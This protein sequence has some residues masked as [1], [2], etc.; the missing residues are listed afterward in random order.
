MRVDPIFSITRI[1]DEEPRLREI[2]DWE[3]ERILDISLVIRYHDTIAGYVD[4][5][6]TVMMVPGLS[7]MYRMPE[8]WL[9]QKQME[10]IVDMLCTELCPTPYPRADTEDEFWKDNPA[11]F[12]CGFR[13]SNHHNNNLD[14]EAWQDTPEHL[15]F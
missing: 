14:C 9:Y 1:T 3:P 5:Y 12:K 15:R 4:E 10:Y 7:S 8:F 6:G 11:C 2:F 13:K